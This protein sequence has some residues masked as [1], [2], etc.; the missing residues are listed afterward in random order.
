M[1]F[2]F[3]NQLSPHL[4]RA[5]RA[6]AQPDGQEIWH[7]RDKFPPSTKD[8]EWIGVLAQEGEWIIISGDLDIIRTRAERPIWKSAGLTG[9][10]LKKGWMALD[11][12]EQ[13]WR[14]VKWWPTIVKFAGTAPPGSTFA[15]PINPNGRLEDN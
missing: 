11:P 10:F 7:L 13:G 12:W 8:L 14:L 15:V 1:R 3:D 5:I 4:A 6:L 9:F 2:F